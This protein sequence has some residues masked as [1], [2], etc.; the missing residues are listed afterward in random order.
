MAKRVFDGWVDAKSYKMVDGQL[1]WVK[2]KVR[3]ELSIDIER[4]MQQLGNKVAVSK[5]GRSVAM[6]GAV[7]AKLLARAPIKADAP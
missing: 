5:R 2:E 7:S 4:V 3:V 1:Q 6:A